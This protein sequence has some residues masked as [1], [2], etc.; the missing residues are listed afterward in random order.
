MWVDGLSQIGSVCVMNKFN[1]ALKYIPGVSMLRTIRKKIRN[2]R[3]K[4]R[5]ISKFE[6]LLPS[7]TARLLKN[8]APYESPSIP[9]TRVG[10]EADGGYIMGDVFDKVDAAYSFGIANDVTWD[11]EIAERSIPVYM[12]DHTIDNLPEKHKNFHFFKI[13]ICGKP[14][15][16]G[17]KDIGTLIRENGHQGKNLLMKMDIEGFEYPAISALR[18]EEIA[19]FTQ[20]SM[21]L[22]DLQSLLC[23]AEKHLLISGCL[24]KILRHMHCIHIHANNVGWVAEANGIKVPILLELLFI[25]KDMAT[26]FKRTDKLRTDLDKPNNPEI[27]EIDISMLW[28]QFADSTVSLLIN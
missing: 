6:Q 26:D 14:N 2:I 13:G 8:L 1:F 20:I 12:Y 23:D 3:S 19:Q 11:K 17:M 21:E 18:E 9:L 4:I 22:H 25:R 5:L 7:L 24:E 16:K 28:K 27:D 15:K 10:N